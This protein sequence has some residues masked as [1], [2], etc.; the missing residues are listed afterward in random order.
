MAKHFD[1]GSPSDGPGESLYWFELK[2]VSAS[3]GRTYRGLKSANAFAGRGGGFF[4]LVD[5]S[6]G[7]GTGYDTAYIAASKADLAVFDVA[8]AVKVSLRD[9]PGKFYGATEADSMLSLSDKPG[10]L[11][12]EICI[13]EPG[14]QV[15]KRAAVDGFNIRLRQTG[16]RAEPCTAEVTLRGGWYGNLKTSK[17]ELQVRAEDSNGNGVYGDKLQPESETCKGCC[18]DMIYIIPAKRGGR[19]DPI[20]LAEAVQI[21]GQLY[22]VDVSKT[23]NRLDIKPYGGETGFLSVGATDGKG[24]GADC[25]D[26]SYSGDKGNFSPVDDQP[27]KVP[28]GN[29]RCSASIGAGV[30][31][32]SPLV[33]LGK[34][35]TV[36]FAIGGPLHFEVAPGTDAI[37]AKAGEDKQIE[38]TVY[39]GQDIMHFASCGKFT[40]TI[41]DAEGKTVAEQTVINHR[42]EVQCTQVF[43]IPKSLKPGVYTVE[44]RLDARPYQEPVSVKKK[45]VV[46]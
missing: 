22:S 46:E 38:M 45:L 3:S 34:D 26:I 35:R 10:E 27:A 13:G 4:V 37:R 20:E 30:Y 40:A 31:V 8:Q 7:S 23:G 29:Y 28:V 16:A 42:S 19:E 15:I 24:R 36:R 44:V 17:G 11:S 14:D 25:E 39:A 18:G 12:T 9:N 5:E 43:T 6:K 1:P 21:D 2:P 41:T 32:A 33:A